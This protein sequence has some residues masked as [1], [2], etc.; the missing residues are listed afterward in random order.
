MFGGLRLSNV[1]CRRGP[2]QN[3]LKSRYLALVGY[4]V[5]QCFIWDLQSSFKKDQIHTAPDTLIRVGFHFYGAA[6]AA[7]GCQ[8]KVSADTR[9]H[10]PGTAA[11]K[12]VTCFG[13]PHPSGE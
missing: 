8:E 1:S 12:A 7:G 10:R 2:L 5:V 9:G 11:L 4:K 13:K 3:G 6:C